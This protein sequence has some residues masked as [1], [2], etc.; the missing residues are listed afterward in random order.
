M[1]QKLCVGSFNLVKN[2]S[3]FNKDLIENYNEDSDKGYYFEVDFQYLQKLYELHGD[4][5]FLPE[6][7]E[8][9]KV[10]NL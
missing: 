2:S 6:R 9:E 4:L 1:S 7:L 10:K 5:S 3:H 8:T